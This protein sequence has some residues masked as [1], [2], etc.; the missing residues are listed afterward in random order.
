MHSPKRKWLRKPDTKRMA[1]VSIS[2]GP[3]E[4]SGAGRRSRRDQSQPQ[5]FP[6]GV[7][8][9]LRVYLKLRNLIVR[10]AI[11]FNLW[12]RVG[13]ASERLQ[14]QGFPQAVPGGVFGQRG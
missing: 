4:D 3:A 12:P 8:A 5:S 2:P 11:N 10:M 9:S 1:A 6:R 13:R 7:M 14:N